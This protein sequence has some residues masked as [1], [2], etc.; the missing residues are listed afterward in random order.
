MN[1]VYFNLFLPSGPE[2]AGG[3]PVVLINHGGTATKQGMVL[4]NVATMAKHGYAILLINFVGNGF[5]PLSTLTVSPT[6]G[7]P[8]T[9]SAGGRG[10]DQNGDGDIGA[11]EGRNTTEPNTLIGDRDAYRQTVA[12]WMQVVREI[13]VG[14]DV[15]GDGMR[16]LDP[17]RI[18]YFG[19]SLGGNLGPLL[20]A[21]EPDITSGVFVSPAAGGTIQSHRLSAVAPVLGAPSPRSSTGAVLQSRTPSLINAP[22]LTSIGGVPV[23]GPYFNE[24]MPLRNQLP[25]VNTITGA[26]AIQEFFEHCEWVGMP[27]DPSAYAPYLRKDPLPGVPA[28]QVLIVLSMG[29][30]T[31]ANPS[32]TAV[33]RAGD[34]ADRTV[35]YRNDLAYAEDNRVSKNPHMFSIQI[36]SPV[37]L[38]QKIALAVQELIATF[39]ADG[40]VIID[41]EVARFFESPIAGPLPEDLNFIV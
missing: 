21:V 18:S 20:V 12:D 34:L 6:G 25:V 33:I 31:A 19:G 35:L 27:A 14:M 41:P 9:F 17:A 39:F 22:G 4:G 40:A 11:A 16:D 29:D 32:T 38:V 1:E 36:E 7:S 10:F 24:N 23:D 37:P 15:D 30:E 13:Q 5:G 3:W 26:M 28:K 8:V 2:P